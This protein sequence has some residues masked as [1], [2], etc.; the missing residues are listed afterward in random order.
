MKAKNRDTVRVKAPRA[1]CERMYISLGT[2]AELRM[3][4]NLCTHVPE[5]P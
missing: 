3:P 4:N 2:E 5:T 1:W